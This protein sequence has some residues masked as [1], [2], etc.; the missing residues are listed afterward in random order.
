MWKAI[1]F[2]VIDLL[3]TAFRVR[4]MNKKYL[5]GNDLVNFWLKEAIPNFGNGVTRKTLDRKYN[6]V[7]EDTFKKFAFIDPTDKFK[8]FKESFDCDDFAL[9]FK[10]MMALIFGVNS[11]GVVID[12]SGGHAYNVVLLSNGSVKF[13]EPQTDKW[14][15]VGEGQKYELKAGLILL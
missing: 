9:N 8:Y 2:Y 6:V 12:D 15:E 1:L 13:F 11:I 7:S 4:F 3:W 5:V 14:L 10:A